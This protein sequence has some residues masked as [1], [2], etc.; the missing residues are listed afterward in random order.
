MI[1]SLLNTLFT[2][3]G[4]NKLLFHSI[5]GLIITL[6]VMAGGKILKWFLNSAGKRLISHTQTDIDDKI[7]EIILSRIIALS[8]IIGVYLGMRE[9]RYGLT[10]KND[11]F[12]GFLSLAD[13]T[14]YVVTII[15]LTSLAIRIVRTLTSHTIQTIA[16]KNKQ[17]DF[18]QT[19]SPLA[20]RVVTIVV[21][22][23][24]AIVVL[25]HFNYSVTS[26]LT[27]LGA[28]SLALGLAAQD[29][30]SNMISGF[31]IMIDR[32]FRVG[33]RIKIPSGE[34]GD[35]FEIG[36]RSTKILDFDNNMLIV[37]NNE[38]IKTKIV[39]YAYPADEIRVIV[40]IGVAYG[41]DV[42]QVKQLMVSTAK[43][44]PLVL[45]EPAPECFLMN[46]GESSLLFRLVCRVA[47]FQDQPIVA[48]NLRVQIYQKF[49]EQKVEIPFPQRV[50]HHTYEN[51]NALQTSSK[52]KKI[53]R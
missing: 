46:F 38:L 6:C 3:L 7:L 9:I 19:L 47:T 18:Q 2:I 42:A 28:G 13:N 43:K 12:L 23:F 15:I 14:L 32:P 34:V 8:S 26:L 39:N 29:T 5:L 53:Q 36:M 30:I 35:I 48:E 25:E 40:E 27:I 33:D 4:G 17:K 24:A 51:T 50:V 11:N 10:L 16:E 20:N 45:K 1:E 41:T 22:A 31:V 49:N 21:I 44:H 37:P 52:R